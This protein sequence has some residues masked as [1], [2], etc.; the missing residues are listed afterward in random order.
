MAV[1]PPQAPLP[2]QPASVPSAPRGRGC[3]GRSCGCSCLGCLGATV[4][5]GLLVLGS[6]YWLLVVQ[7]QAAVTA[8]ATLIVF[9]QP[10]TVNGGAS[11]AG[12]GPHPGRTGATPAKGHPQH[13]LP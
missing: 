4:L 5:A 10:V 7:A 11:T 1:Q 13:P 12:E 3:F 6:G 8:P 2:T 9:N